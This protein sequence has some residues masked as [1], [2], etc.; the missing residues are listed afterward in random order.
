MNT[1]AIFN[2]RYLFSSTYSTNLSL[3]SYFFDDLGYIIILKD[4]WEGELD[5]SDQVYH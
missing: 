4:S 2:K 1:E 5:I 3:F